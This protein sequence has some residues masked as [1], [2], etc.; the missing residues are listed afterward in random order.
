MSAFASQRPMS[1]RP[2]ADIVAPD[3]KP[4]ELT[5][6]PHLQLNENVDLI[7]LRTREE[8]GL[9]SYGWIDQ[10]AG[11]VRIPIERA[12][13]LIV[14]RGLPETNVVGQSDLE[15]IRERSQSR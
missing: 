6:A 5:V 3:S 12:M 9:N 4:I 11:V 14:A 7:A 8:E 2:P 1:T 10:T 15:L 13:D